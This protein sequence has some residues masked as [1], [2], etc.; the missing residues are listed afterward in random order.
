MY[1]IKLNSQV[2]YKYFM[3]LCGSEFCLCHLGNSPLSFRKL[4][5]SENKLQG[6]LYPGLQLERP[7]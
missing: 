2:H 1:V 4:P 6:F 7:K 5:T 3:H